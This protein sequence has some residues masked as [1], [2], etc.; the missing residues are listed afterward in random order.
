VPAQGASASVTPTLSGVLHDPVPGTDIATFY[1]RTA[2][3]GSWDVANGAAV[4][5]AAG[6]RASY[7]VPPGRLLPGTTYEW[8]MRACNDAG[9]CSAPTVVL[10]FTTRAPAPTPSPSATATAT[11]AP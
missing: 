10:R 11:V 1:V 4:R 3:S 5:A 2:G 6:T 8:R 7:A 9:L